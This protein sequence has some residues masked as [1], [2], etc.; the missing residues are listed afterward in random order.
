MIARA[1]LVLLAVLT[2]LAMLV[3]TALCTDSFNNP[4]NPGVR[5]LGVTFLI[6]GGTAA[7]ANTYIIYFHAVQPPHPKFL[8]TWDHRLA[9]RAHAIAGATETVLGIVAWA[10]QSSAL[11][12]A[13]GLVALVQIAAAYYQ[14]PGVSGMKGVTVPLYYAAISV[15]LFCAVNLIATGDVAWLER[16]WITLQTYAYVRITYF[17]LGRTHA[18]RGSAYTVSVI[19]GGAVTLP[20]VLGPIAPFVIIGIVVFYLALYQVIVRP[21]KGEWDA[22]FVEHVRRSLVPQL[23]GAWSR[24][25]LELPDGLSPREEAEIAFQRLDADGSGA[26]DLEEIESVLTAMGVSTRLHDSFRHRH[27]RGEDT[28]ISFDTFL[29]TL[30]LPSHV[31]GTTP[32]QRDPGLSEQEQARIVF[33]RLDI[34]ATG[35]IDEFAI[36]ILL[37][38]WGM[39]LHEAQRT[40]RKL[41]G[42]EHMRYSFDDFH[43]RLKPI[44]RYGYE[45]MTMDGE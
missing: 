24:L 45:T 31:T 2:I 9:I 5:T 36:E 42:P 11:A 22:L 33:D 7:V 44:W 39:E 41:S 40:V 32:L 28:A 8:L 21:T 35:Y 43:G 12:V 27:D 23:Q 10:T 16:T 25:G 1:K 15:H 14:S 3:V 13:T 17:L 37:L 30:W 26:L 4:L 29:A 34:G 18:F 20:F 38:E 19:L 6:V